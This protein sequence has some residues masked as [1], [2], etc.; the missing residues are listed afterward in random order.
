M[1]RILWALFLFLVVFGAGV[2]VAKHYFQSSDE[3][4]QDSQIIVE[5]IEKVCKLVTVEGHFVEYYDYGDPP[6]G[7]LFIGPFINF[8][9]LMPRKS[10]QM[11]VRATV[12]VGYDLTNLEVEAF[13]EEQVIRL[14]RI[15]EPAVMAVDHEVDYFDDQSSIFRPLS[16][17]DFVEMGKG[18]EQMIRDAAEAG[19]LLDAAREQGN[20]V[21]DLIEFIVTTSGWK[22]EMVTDS[23][24]SNIEFPQPSPLPDT[25]ATGEK[26]PA[27]SY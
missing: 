16:D 17:E 15:P 1:K 18:A 19:T 12:S 5:Q 6:K 7:P 24:P 8:E 27:G 10:A 21:F 20:E 13:P 23:L 11:R 4:V 3:M 14:S 2:F 22:L 25:P 9:A 26:W